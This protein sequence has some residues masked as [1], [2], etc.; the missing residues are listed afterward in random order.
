M[1]CSCYSFGGGYIVFLTYLFAFLFCGFVCMIAQIIIDNTKLTPGHVT[2]LFVVIG[3]VLEFFNLYDYLRNFASMGASLVIS[4]FG[5]TIMK[6]VKEAVD[7]LGISGIFTGIF[8][9][10]GV[11]ISF[12]VFLAFTASLFFKPKS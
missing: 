10:C 12:A 5:S 6:G 9:K 8:S 4:S 3:V 2:S 7:N 11:L 1:Y